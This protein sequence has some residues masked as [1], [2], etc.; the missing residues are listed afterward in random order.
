VAHP[1]PLVSGQDLMTNLR[2]S[3]GPQIGQLLAEIQLARAEGFIA[4]PTDALEWAA[5]IA[6]LY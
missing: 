2:L 3:P 5:K 4:T 1:V 6:Q